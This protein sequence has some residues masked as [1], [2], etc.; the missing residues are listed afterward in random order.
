MTE[1]ILGPIGDKLAPELVSPL[2]AYLAHESC[3]PTGRVFSIAGGRIAEV[4]IAEGQGYVNPAM[5]PEDV[6]A[7]LDAISNRDDYVIP[8]QMNDESACISSTWREQPHRPVASDKL[9]R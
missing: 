8:T 5:T 6:A 7:N 9:R 3:E 2:V 1:G 4:F